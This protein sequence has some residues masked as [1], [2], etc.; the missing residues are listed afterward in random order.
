MTTRIFYV[1]LILFTLLLQGCKDE[2]MIVLGENYPKQIL[3]PSSPTR[4]KKPEIPESE[5]QSIPVAIINNDNRKIS[6]FLSGKW[7]E[8]SQDSLNEFTKSKS[9]L[10]Y[11]DSLERDWQLYN[12]VALN[13][14]K[15][16]L[17]E[18]F[19]YQYFKFLYI[20]AMIIFHF[21]NFIIINF[22]EI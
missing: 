3:I 12:K 13:P 19:K 22:V 11:K 6:N 1:L 7:V 21:K 5:K 16:W 18:N 20:C 8:D 4:E 2:S 14:F 9:Y 17:G 15:E 10:K